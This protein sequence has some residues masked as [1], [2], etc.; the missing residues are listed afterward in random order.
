MKPKRI[1]NSH[2]EIKRDLKVLK[3]KQQIAHEELR[4]IQYKLKDNLKPV[5]LLDSVFSAL[6]K[7][8]AIL[9]VKTVLKRRV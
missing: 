5:N 3:L 8:G 7:Y 2:K 4:L 1:Y 9:L 6:K